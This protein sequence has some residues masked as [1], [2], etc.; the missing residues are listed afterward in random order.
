MGNGIG[1]SRVLRKAL[2]RASRSSLLPPLSPP[3]PNTF[4][5]PQVIVC[6]ILERDETH[7]GIIWNTAVVVGN[8][9]NI[10]GKHRKVRAGT[11]ACVLL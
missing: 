7:V 10:I 8:N 3:A 6:P 4:F 11:T 9:G 2:K 1:H 5:P